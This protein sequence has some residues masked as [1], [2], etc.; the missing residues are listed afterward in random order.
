MFAMLTNKEVIEIIRQE[1]ERVKK[2][3]LTYMAREI[4]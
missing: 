4:K 2:N 1:Q 3:H